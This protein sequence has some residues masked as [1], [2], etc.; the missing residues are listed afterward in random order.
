M[1]LIGPP[2]AKMGFP[3]Q[4]PFDL[5]EQW[6]LQNA[7]F[8]SHWQ[9]RIVGYASCAICENQ[10]YVTRTIEWEGPRKPYWVD[11]QDLMAM[12]LVGRS[13]YLSYT[14]NSASWGETLHSARRLLWHN[15]S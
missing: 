2:S 10:G 7:T 11:P 12:K 15:L 6:Q 9:P 8:T 5:H 13:R 1:L 14:P 3:R 4:Q